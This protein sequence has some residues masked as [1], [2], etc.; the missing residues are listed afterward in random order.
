[1]R[2]FTTG[3]V[4]A[5]PKLSKTFIYSNVDVEAQFPDGDEALDSLIKDQLYIPDEILAPIKEVGGTVKARCIVKALVEIDGTISDAVIEK[6]TTSPVFDEEALRVVKNLPNFIPARKSA[7]LPMCDDHE[8]VEG[9]T[10][11]VRSWKL[12]PVEFVYAEGYWKGFRMRHFKM[13]NDIRILSR[14]IPVGIKTTRLILFLDMLEICQDCC[15]NRRT[16]QNEFHK[17]CCTRIIDY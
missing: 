16:L 13:V 8:D 6:T 5:P 17:I 4:D 1:M 14:I 12:I 15:F 9:P 3:I 11:P 7:T 10:V 2:K